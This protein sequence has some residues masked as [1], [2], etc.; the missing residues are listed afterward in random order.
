MGVYE[1]KS[2]RK[3]VRET[4]TPLPLVGSEQY[5]RPDVSICIVRKSLSLVMTLKMVN[6]FYLFIQFFGHKQPGKCVLFK[7]VFHIEHHWAHLSFLCFKSIF[8][9]A[10]H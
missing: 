5:I 1:S 9:S 4:N 8:S 10:N 3:Q 7:F 2:S 6:A